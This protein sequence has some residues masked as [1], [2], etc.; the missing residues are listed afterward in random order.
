MLAS[1]FV[2]LEVFSKIV[3]NGVFGLPI[4]QTLS[5]Q[6]FSCGAS[7]ET[8]LDRAVEYF[9]SLSQLHR[10]QPNGHV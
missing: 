7:I 2:P 4:E 10:G 5:L 3:R 9:S 8:T 6:I 1:C